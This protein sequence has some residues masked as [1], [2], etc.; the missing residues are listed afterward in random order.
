MSNVWPKE[1]VNFSITINIE[2]NG[3]ACTYQ[4]RSEVTFANI[5]YKKVAECMNIKNGQVAFTSNFYRIVFGYHVAWY[6]LQYKPTAKAIDSRAYAYENR[7]CEQHSKNVNVLWM[8]YMHSVA[9]IHTQAVM[10]THWN[11]W[12]ESPSGWTRSESSNKLLHSSVF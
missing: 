5:D 3:I 8:Y 2:P 10:L 7:H 6:Y 12:V 4:T 9:N 1:T 11:T